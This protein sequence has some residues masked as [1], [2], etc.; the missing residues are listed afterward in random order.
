[1]ERRQRALTIPQ[2][3][4]PMSDIGPLTDCTPI[5]YSVIP[6]RFALAEEQRVQN[7]FETFLGK[8]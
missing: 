7:F 3:I 5:T 6:R 4:N 1:M 2:P 8:D